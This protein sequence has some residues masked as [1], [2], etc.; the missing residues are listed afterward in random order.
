MAAECTGKW[1]YL[2]RKNQHADCL[3]AISY[4]QTLILKK[5]L[6]TAEKVYKICSTKGTKQKELSAPLGK[7]YFFYKR[8][9][10][11]L[12]FLFFNLP[13][14][15]MV[16]GTLLFCVDL[17]DVKHAVRIFLIL[18]LQSGRSQ[19]HFQSC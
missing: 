8:F 17:S 3:T 1:S 15:L 18:I 11:V 13:F 9:C 2:L 6:C 7:V 19:K 12:L 5:P 4:L 10:W 16:S 14:E